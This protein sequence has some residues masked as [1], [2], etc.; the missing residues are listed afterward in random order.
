MFFLM[1]GA[2]GDSNHPISASHCQA[3]TLTH[4]PTASHRVIRPRHCPG[5]VTELSVGGL[6]VTSDKGREGTTLCYEATKG[7]LDSLCGRTEYGRRCWGCSSPSASPC[8][9]FPCSSKGQ[10]RIFR[11]LRT[12]N[13]NLKRQRDN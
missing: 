6:A 7:Q 8:L 2:T 13:I 10:D 9:A 5:S 4:S 11:D 12:G 3:L 1:S